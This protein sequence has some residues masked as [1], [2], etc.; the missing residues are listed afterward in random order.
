MRQMHSSRDGACSWPVVTD[1]HHTSRNR[2]MRPRSAPVHRTASSYSA[3]MPSPESSPGSSGFIPTW[4][5]QTR[6]RSLQLPGRVLRLRE[7]PGSFR[8]SSGTG[9]GWQRGHWRT[10]SP[11]AA[12]A[13]APL[14][15]VEPVLLT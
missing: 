5:R 4:I 9:S 12:P 10:L 14:E 11:L 6:A 3:P 8:T 13:G 1:T 2:L 7:V 15:W